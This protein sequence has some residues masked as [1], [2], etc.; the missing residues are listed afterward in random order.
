MRKLGVMFGSALLALAM[1][2]S[3]FAD[4]GGGPPATFTTINFTF[5][6]GADHCK[7]G[8]AG[9]T[10]VVN[11]NIYDGKQYVWLNG[12]PDNAALADG[13]Y[14]FAVL[15]PG[16]QHDPNDGAGKNLSDTSVAPYAA[17]S[18][19]ADGSGIPSGDPRSNRTFSVSGGIIAYA[20]THTF[21]SQMIR[22]M[23]YDDT[24][25][26]GGVYILAIC[27]LATSSSAVV[28]KDCKYDAFKVQA[29]GTPVTVQAVLSG[30]KY[31]DANTNGQIDPGETGLSGWTINISDG[32]TTTPVV[33]DSEGNWSFNTPEVALGT[34]ET[35]TISEVQRSGFAQTGNT[36]DQSSAT[37]GV[38]VALSNKIYTLTL[39]NTG[40]GSASGLNFGN[41][42]LASA[43][44]ATKDATP[45]F[46][47][48]FKWTI[49][50]D[51]D[52]TEI[53]TADGATF[54]Y[55]VSVTRDAGTDNA[56]AVSGSIAVNNPNSA[57]VTVNVSDA[58]NDAN[59]TCTVT[60]GTGAIIPASGSASLPYSC[61]YSALFASSSQTNTASI[62]WAQQ[63]LSNA[64]LL[65]TGSASGTAAIAWDGPTTVVDAS[66]S[67]S[68]PL[69]PSA[70]RTFSS[71]GSFSYSHTY[72]GDPA[73]TCTDHK[74]TATFTTNT[75]GTTGSASQTVKVCV[76]ADLTVSKTATPTF[77][78]TFTWGISKAVDQ[79]R[80]NIASGGS[81]TFNY[82]VNV[83]HDK[84]TDSAW[85]VTGTITV[86]N[87]N[88]WE[89]ITADV[90]DAV[91]NLGICS[92]IGGGTNVTVPRSG[93]AILSYAC[94]YLV[95]PSPLAGTNTATATWNSS[96][97]A[98]PTGSASGAAAAAFGDPTTIID[99]TIAVTD[100]LGGSLGSASYTDA[101][102]KTFTYAKTF[103]TDAAGTC[104]NHDNT[105]TFTTNIG[106]TGSASQ[107]VKVCVGADL[108]VSKTA[109]STFTR[110]YASTITKSADK[111]LVKLLNGSATFTYT[112]VASETGFTDSAWVAAG[113]ITVNNPNDW[114]AI[115]ANVT[116]AVGN[117]GT[118]LVTSGTSLSIPASGSKQL[119]YAC[120]YAT[121]PSPITGTNTA[122][123][124]WDKTT[125]L[126]PNGSASGT[127]GV[128]FT[129]PTTLVNSTITVTD[130]FAG[131]LG[132]V[133]ATNTTPFATRT[134]TYT[135]TVPA[136]AHDCV[137]VP[138]TASF[139][140]SDGPATGSASQTVSVCRIPPLTGALTMG[141]W[142]NKNGQGIIL[143]GASTAGV[144]NSGTSLRTY[145]PYQDLSATATCSQVAA[146]VYNIIKVANS[147]GDS[148]NPM[149]KAQMLA[150]ALDVYFSDP[151]LGGNQIKAP[152]PVGGVKIDLTQICAMI[153]SIG[154]STCS[155]SYENVSG[156]FGGATSLTVSQ[157][158][159][160]AAS[161]SNVGGSTWYGNVKATQ[162]LAKDAFDAINNQVAF[163]AP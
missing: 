144:C 159:T 101:S 158:L 61:S 86:A 140:A 44:T 58:I 96:T 94:T 134:F 103:S 57:P 38:G 113:K 115:T 22:L 79:T 15:A 10:Q 125:F 26:E 36:T 34:L 54:T 64:T 5:D 88:D 91:N 14:F 145:A 161:Q 21:D 133:T 83:T 65:L 105:A 52:K 72:T 155:G 29:P 157:M 59:A 9:A 107:S 149:L 99:G 31:L 119:D 68:D 20:G 78:R 28:P 92:V 76:G 154:S 62:S 151:A 100:T 46:T 80:I 87:P 12:G 16:G 138:N 42:P 129:T 71:T 128:D 130:T 153:D 23:P 108:T 70:P 152:A 8:P 136:P 114:E 147:S 74:N 95:A 53:D 4:A 47:R 93:S 122:T 66:V 55:T 63:T 11:C 81:A 127:A 33:T 51:V 156:S 50:K 123:A 84:G 27:K 148:M 82:T 109:L 45:A 6:G 24:T 41:I 48:T 126:T 139:T 120:A 17:G 124:S 1:L 132:T 39:P 25:N 90:S 142:Q 73:G 18:L 118:C 162:Q 2:P 104:T 32:T 56:W 141:F 67:V 77:T 117:G 43:L 97:Y 110:T 106:T 160:Y 69:D 19:N 75:S 131:L 89:D 37:G 150:T 102:P 60:G 163:Q 30:T 98:T 135:R 13:T 85:A 40:P 3:A 116:D 121:K 112:I 143:G 111:T 49:K 146:Y 35:F 137:S 7:N